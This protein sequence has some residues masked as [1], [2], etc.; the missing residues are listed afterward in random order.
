MKKEDFRAFP[1][2]L[3]RPI[4]APRSKKIESP[5]AGRGGANKRTPKRARP[6]QP[7]R[8]FKCGM[9]LVSEDYLESHWNYECPG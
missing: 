4:A 5:G 9:Q 8:C 7:V 1:R 6:R 3:G 2:S